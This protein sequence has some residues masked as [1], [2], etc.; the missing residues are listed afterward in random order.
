MDLMHGMC[1]MRL[2][3]LM[4]DS[5]RRSGDADVA[6][7]RAGESAV[8]LATV[9]HS[10]HLPGVARWY[11]PRMATIWGESVSV[12]PLESRLFLAAAPSS[13]PPADAGVVRGRV[14]LDADRSGRQSKGEAGVSGVIVYLDA[15]A[16][17][18]RQPGE[19]T[20]ETDAKG[21]YAVGG[22]APGEHI[23]RVELPELAVAS[24]ADAATAVVRPGRRA[25]KATP[26][27]VFG[28][29]MIR[30]TVKKVTLPLSDKRPAVGFRVFA[31][32]NEDDKW[33]RG[34]PWA[35]TDAE[36]RY[37][38]RGLLVGTYPLWV[39]RRGGWGDGAH[40]TSIIGGAF[41]AESIANFEVRYGR[42]I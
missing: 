18:T 24:G 33:Q 6:G 8:V 31:D 14:F 23:V 22:L 35:K 4:C 39:Q 5:H 36:G 13:P 30:G 2:M 37:E 34:E 19:P 15:D 40:F 17:G 11:T 12:E 28:T 32:L 16:S 21:M 42:R 29:G 3:R 20:A 25:A 27:G 10:G 7:E 1:L 38:M 9:P 26:L 41:D